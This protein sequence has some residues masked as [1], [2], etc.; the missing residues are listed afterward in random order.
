MLE[1]P[2]LVEEVISDDDFKQLGQMLVR[3]SFVETTIA[4]C[5][6]KLLRLT[7]EEATIMIVPL[8]L[9]YRMDKI[10]EISKQRKLKKKAQTALDELCLCIKAMQALR[11]GIVHGV[12]IHDNEHGFSFHA[13]KSKVNR[14]KKEIFSAMEFVNYTGHVALAFRYELGIQ[15][16]Q[17]G[18]AHYG[19][20]DRP[21]IPEFLQSY[22]PKPKTPNK[23]A[24]KRPP[25]SSRAKSLSR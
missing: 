20:P 9:G 7:K 10:V 4:N 22:F 12:A 16:M 21:H 18:L 6:K 3:W 14:N 23:A 11:N 8:N 15:G 1:T 13:L 19:L 17:V 24:Q 25:R 5:L 2:Y